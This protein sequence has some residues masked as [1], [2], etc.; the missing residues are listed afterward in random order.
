[1]STEEFMKELEYLLSDIPEEEKADAIGYYRD[2]LEEAG[3][4]NG[5]EA[6]RGFGSPERIAAIIRSELTG[7]M[8]EGGE[9]TE[10]GYEDER[11]RDPSYQ[12]ARRYELPE[13]AEKA[14][15][16]CGETEPPRTNRTVKLILW[17]VLIIAAAPV[18]FGI[19]GGVAGIAS[20][21][22]GILLAAIVALGAITFALFV[23][24]VA[25]VFAGIVTMVVSPLNGALLV[26]IALLIF[27]I[28]MGFLALCG[29]FYGRF[30]PFLFRTVVNGISG[31]INRRRERL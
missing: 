20:G 28:A 3:A 27:G 12:V 4:E 6:I 18:L 22:L 31:I 29:V 7:G 14:G 9:F 24:G 19:G 17:I 5:E 2:Y 11:F 10:R 30:L 8:K 15:N 25:L 21:I 23:S 1:M 26:G 16:G 13:E